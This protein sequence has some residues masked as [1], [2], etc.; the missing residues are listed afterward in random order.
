ML[1]NPTEKGRSSFHMLCFNFKYVM[2]SPLLLSELNLISLMSISLLFIMVVV[3]L[4]HFYPNESY[5]AYQ[6]GG[7]ATKTNGPSIKNDSF[8]YHGVKLSKVT[9]LSIFAEDTLPLN[10]RAYELP[11]ITIYTEKILLSVRISVFL[12]SV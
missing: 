1:S 6:R 8:F 2:F 12:R 7:V 4:T 11:H 9:E 10:V 3:G 5:L